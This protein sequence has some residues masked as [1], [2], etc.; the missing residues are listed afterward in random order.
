M[1]RDVLEEHDERADEAC[2]ARTFECDR[3][4]QDDA[5]GGEVEEHECEEELPE[6]RHLRYET[7][8]GVGD[9]A[10]DDWWDDAQWEDVEQDLGREVGEGRVVP[11][12]PMRPS[13]L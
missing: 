11:I 6:H 5:R 12:R 9:P 3:E 13:A 7:D 1:W 4:E 10:K 8:P 2:D